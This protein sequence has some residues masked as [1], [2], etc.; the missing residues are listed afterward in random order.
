MVDPVVAGD[1]FTYE[2][3]AL[4]QWLSSAHGVPKSPL[5]NRPMESTAMHPNLTLRKLI[6]EWYIAALD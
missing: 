6:R 1:G 2:R 3:E 4:E 5:T